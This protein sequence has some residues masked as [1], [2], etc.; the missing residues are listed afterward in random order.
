MIKTYLD[1]LV[2]LPWKKASEDRTDI[3]NARAVLDEDH[4]GLQDVK[5]R[6]IEYLAVRKLV[7]ERG[8]KRQ[9]RER[10]GVRGHGRDPVLCRAS[11]CRQ[12]QPGQEHRPGPRAAASPA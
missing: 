1:W 8:V 5:E 11:G 2:D 12:D 10:F 9:N 4:Y 3:D 6:I 7:A